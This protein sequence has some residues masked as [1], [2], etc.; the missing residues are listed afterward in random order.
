MKSNKLEASI[1]ILFLLLFAVVSRGFDIVPPFATWWSDI[2]WSIASGAAAWRTLQVARACSGNARKGWF[3]ISAANFVWFIGIL[4]WDFHEL[5]LGDAT[6]YPGISDIGFIAFAF[7]I[8]FGF[9]QL[10]SSEYQQPSYKI[11][12]IGKLG[13]VVTSL[14]ITHMVFFNLPLKT[15][16]SSTLY[17]ITALAYPVIYISAF[18]FSASLF[19]H[20]THPVKEPVINFLLLGLAIH[21]FAVSFYAY[22]LLGKNYQTGNYIDIFWLIAF[23][24]TYWAASIQLRNS[25]SP[26]KAVEKT[27][28]SAINFNLDVFLPIAGLTLLAYS[29]FSSRYEL[30][31]ELISNVFPIF[32]LLTLFLGLREWASQ[33]LE[34]SL[35]KARKLSEDKVVAF[36][37]ELDKLVHTRTKE[38]LESRKMLEHVIN[39]IPVRVFWKD[40]NLNYLGCNKI[41]AKDAG[42]NDQNDIIGKNDFN[43]TW[44]NE[45]KLYRNDDKEVIDTGK[46][47][48]NFEEPQSTPDGN[49]IWLETSKT[50]LTDT[51]DNIIGI[52]GTYQD[53]TPRKQTEEALVN[54]KNEAENANLAKS[55][56]LSS[57]S[58]E[59]RTP[60]NAIL[61]FSQLLE[62]DEKDEKKRKN[63][64]E[65]IKG[66]NHLLN[67]INQM[68]DLVKIESGNVELSIGNHSLHKMLNDS[69]SMIKPFADKH[70]IQ[71]DDKVSSLPDINISVDEMRF[72]QVLLNF[73]SNAIKYNSEKGKV[74]IDCSSNDKNMFYLSITDTGKGFTA[75]QLSH[76][77]EPFER[78]E[79]ENSN[80]EG[81]GLGLVIAKDLID[82]MGGNITV[83]SVLGKGSCFIIQ[84]PLS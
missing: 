30:T 3:L 32:I 13:I 64:Q 16:E 7:L 59:L 83:E 35:T 22:S 49:K 84:I 31:P 51:D 5:I 4:N 70:A 41:F 61:G 67:L 75:D 47:K 52:L 29:I 63:I 53:I 60:L 57:M 62:M 45:A 33:Q 12:Q 6:P 23:T 2:A 10:R 20:K 26:E 38:L 48:F 81:T 56:F 66:G 43:M 25:N 80:I 40:L 69:L 55:Q 50:P 68:L 73:L 21:A 36:N 42:L 28:S 72:K 9:Y 24:S 1:V 77:F 34:S 78:F 76:L 11:I 65:V 54:A 46:G 74:T 8:I 39:T 14:L 15:L 18:F 71:I 44:S 17:K 79:A 37:K 58:H 27:D 82:L 19:W